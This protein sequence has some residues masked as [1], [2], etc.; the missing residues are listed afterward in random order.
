VS[1]SDPPA[2]GASAQSQIAQLQ[3]EIQQYQ[4]REQ[5]YQA[6]LDQAGNLIQSYQQVL[7]ALQQSGL[8][9]I[10]RDGRILLQGPND[11]G[12]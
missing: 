1:T 3:A 11:S 10:T 12:G 6:E 7:L 2:S 8:I 5:Q 9:R 4:S